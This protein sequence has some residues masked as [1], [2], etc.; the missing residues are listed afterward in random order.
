MLRYQNGWQNTYSFTYVR[1]EVPSSVVFQCFQWNDS[2]ALFF[3]MLDVTHLSYGCDVLCAYNVLYVDTS[4]CEV[5]M[6]RYMYS[7]SIK[8]ALVPVALEYQRLLVLQS[9]LRN[10]LNL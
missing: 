8:L 1:L 6:Y 9:V 7:S 3:R 5:K 2:R 4:V 10:I